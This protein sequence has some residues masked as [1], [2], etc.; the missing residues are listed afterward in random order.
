MTYRTRE[1]F[2]LWVDVF[3]T[4]ATTVASVWFASR[5]GSREAIR[6]S[7]NEEARK[8]RDL[9]RALENELSLNER[10]LKLALEDWDSREFRRLQIVS[11]AF[12]RAQ[13]AEELFLI[14]PQTWTA[15]VEAYGRRLEES[16]V[17]LRKNGTG[18]GAHRHVVWL[19]YHAERLQAARPMIEKDIAGIE[20]RMRQIGVVDVSVTHTW[21]AEGA[22]TWSD[23]EE[24]ASRLASSPGWER[25]GNARYSGA[26]RERDFGQHKIFYPGHLCN[27][28]KTAGP[29]II[30][31]P[32]TLPSDR[33]PSRL[34]VYLSATCPLPAEEAVSSH[35]SPEEVRRVLS[36]QLPGTLVLCHPLPADANPELSIVDPNRP[37]GWRWA[38][39]A[40]EDDAGELHL[41]RGP[42]TW[43]VAGRAGSPSSFRVPLPGGAL[44]LPKGYLA[45]VPP[46][47]APSARELYD[48]GVRHLAE[49]RPRRAITS[50]NGAVAADPNFALAWKARGDARM[51]CGEPEAAIEDYSAALKLTPE[52]VDLLLARGDAHRRKGQLAVEGQHVP[53]RHYRDAE[54]DYSRAI[55]A[56]GRRG[57][58]WF[59]RALA[60]ADAWDLDHALED[61][62]RAAALD[63]TLEPRAE[64]AAA[65]LR[66][67]LEDRSFTAEIWK[68]G[69]KA[70]QKA[71][72]WNDRGMKSYE[73]REYDASILEWKRAF[74]L[75]GYGEDAV[76]ASYNIACSY[77]LLDDRNR[78][79]H[80][81][82]TSLDRGWKDWVHLL[83]EADFANL[84]M[85]PRWKPLI[86]AKEEE[87]GVEVRRERIRRE[88]REL[89]EEMRRNPLSAQDAE[90]VEREAKDA[91]A[92][93]DF[94][95]AIRAYKRL[96]YSGEGGPSSQWAYRIAVAYARSSD[97]ERAIGWLEIMLAEAPGERERIAQDS[98]FQ[99]LRTDPRLRKLLEKK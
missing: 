2:A 57:E 93:G 15:M 48:Q 22:P 37:L 30:S 54:A 11:P 90:S 42:S 95:K 58:F 82:R 86:G 67:F 32:R 46:A 94:P 92:A 61:L 18:S 41:V 69:D 10:T 68:E 66:G 96:G 74:Y 9:L 35:R 87:L 78:A 79:F 23:G 24:E 26:L 73:K 98:E 19:W 50:F 17:A 13:E 12:A 53:L 62:T 51:A 4:V 3:L 14:D 28:V 88:D 43:K 29:A 56:D 76:S 39:F 34:W 25:Q 40:I 55:E 89:A 33:R 6:F 64:K 45:N 70:V 97:P 65:G 36:G 91:L 27:P 83:L 1:R 8:S 75:T 77:S 85:D 63:A 84:R 16:I 52:S 7:R 31:L 20:A 44:V 38:Y 47:T 71:K 99:S 49:G 60:R 59:R 81:L 80:W 72:D 21:K 5:I